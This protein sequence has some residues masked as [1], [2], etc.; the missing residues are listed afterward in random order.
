MLSPMILK[1]NSRSQMKGKRIRMIRAIGQQVIRRK[2]QRTKAMKVRTDFWFSPIK[3]V[4]CQIDKIHIINV[5]QITALRMYTI[6]IQLIVQN[7]TGNR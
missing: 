3:R 4:S 1:G 7:R 2:A 5:L 6:L